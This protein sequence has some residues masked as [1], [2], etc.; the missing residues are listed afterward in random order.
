MHRLVHQRSWRG[1]ALLWVGC[2]LLLL[3]GSCGGGSSLAGGVDSGGTGSITTLASGPLSGLGSAIVNGVRFDVG[4]ATIVDEDGNSITADQLSLGMVAKIE[5]TTV[6]SA[7][8]QATATAS[9]VLIR[10]QLVGPV[11]SVDLVAQSVV[12]LGQTVQI[13]PATWLDSALTGGLAGSLVGSVI[14]V[15]GQFDLNR[16]QYVATRIAAHLDHS[17]YKI[18]GLVQA[19]DAMANTLTVGSQVFSYALLAPANVPTLAVGDFVRVRIATHAIG[20]VW[21]ALAVAVGH[22]ELP[23]RKD[24]RLKGRIHGWNSTRSFHL[25]GIRINA[26]QALFVGAESA[27][28][29]GARVTVKGYSSGGA[30]TATEVSIDGDETAAN[31]VFELHGSIDAL[32]RGMQTLVVHGVRVSFS[33]QTSYLGGTAGDL[34]LGKKIKVLGVV[35]ADRSSVAA[36]SIAYE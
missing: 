12:V 11:D 25:D 36:Q 31:S 17:A 29:V 22:F 9:S 27:A 21:R 28:V 10:S 35:A 1:H 33:G 15:Y 20:G 5:S 4:S 30:V 16:N 32:D 14:E 2:C 18:A 8:G 24:V 23:D 13:T 19:V 6:Q 26:A 3:L 34:A 7:N